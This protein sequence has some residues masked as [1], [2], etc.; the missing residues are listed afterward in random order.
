[1]GSTQNWQ[2]QA[3]LGHRSFLLAQKQRAENSSTAEGRRKMGKA[4]TNTQKNVA[5]AKTCIVAKGEKC[6]PQTNAEN[7]PQS[8]CQQDRG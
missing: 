2:I 3:D 8:G 5:N 1:V 7:S 6:R 4:A